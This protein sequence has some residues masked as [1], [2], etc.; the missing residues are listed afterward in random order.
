VSSIMPVQTN[1]VIFEVDPSFSA[2][3]IVALFAA[4]GIACN[5]T[6][7]NTIRMVTHLG[8]DAQMMDYALSTIKDLQ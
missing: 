8:I 2:D 5:T 1:I 4:K 3:E 6:S 7:R